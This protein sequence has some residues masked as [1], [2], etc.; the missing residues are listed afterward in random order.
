[1]ISHTHFSVSKV[2]RWL[3]A[4]VVSSSRAASGRQAQKNATATGD[5][6]QLWLAGEYGECVVWCAVNGRQ[7]FVRSGTEELAGSMFRWQ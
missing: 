1:M 3:V 2:S 7:V 6:M 5:E 4:G